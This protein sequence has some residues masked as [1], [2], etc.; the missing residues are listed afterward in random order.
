M[1]IYVG[2]YEISAFI[3]S[4]TCLLW[5]YIFLGREQ[6][7]FHSLLPDVVFFFLPLL[8]HLF[9]IYCMVI[10]RDWMEQLYYFPPIYLLFRFVHMKSK[11]SEFPIFVFLH[12]SELQEFQF[13]SMTKYRCI[14]AINVRKTWLILIIQ[15][16]HTKYIT[17]H[18]IFSNFDY[19]TS[20]QWKQLSPVVT[21]CYYVHRQQGK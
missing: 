15:N 19:L 3:V 16:H 12:G 17:S 11:K 2:I 9:F 7:S 5:V 8:F 14:M 1:L 18:W 6:Y 13:F 20:T 21:K 4:C 10:V